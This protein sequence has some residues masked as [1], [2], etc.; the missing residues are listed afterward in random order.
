MALLGIPLI[1]NARYPMIAAII[2]VVGL[3]AFW[4][5]A[6]MALVVKRLHDLDKTG[7]HYVWM[8]LL[9]GLLTSGLTFQLNSEGRWSIGYGQTAGFIPLLSALYLLFALGSDGPNKFGYPP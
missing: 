5:W 1:D 7:W 8:F 4:G 9:P 2:V 3:A 6:G